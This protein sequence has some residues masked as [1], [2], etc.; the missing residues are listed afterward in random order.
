MLK[1]SGRVHSGMEIEEK[2]VQTNKKRRSQSDKIG[3][4]KYNQLLLNKPCQRLVRDSEN[5]QT[6]EEGIWSR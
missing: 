3:C 2:P 1:I 6:V 4:L 5:E